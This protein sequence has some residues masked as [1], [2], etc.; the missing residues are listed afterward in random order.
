[1]NDT[2]TVHWY[3]HECDWI[4]DHCDEHHYRTTT[5][6]TSA[7]ENF[8]AYVDTQCR[9]A[10]AN[11]LRGVAQGITAAAE[12]ANVVGVHE[13]F[14]RGLDAATVIVRQVASDIKAEP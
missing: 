7:L 2:T 1:M 8:T 12:G 10:Q 11:V 9:K 3:D 14:W 13:A 5:I 4:T 6:P